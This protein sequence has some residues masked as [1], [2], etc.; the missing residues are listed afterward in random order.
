MLL[1]AIA[2]KRAGNQANSIAEIA[3]SGLCI[4]C[5][6][7]QSIAS[8]DTIDIVMTAD[9][10]ERPIAIADIHDDVFEKITKVCPALEIHGLPEHELSSEANMDDVWGQS[11]QIASGY[12]SDSE[13]RFKGATGGVLTGLAVYLLESKQV[14]FIAHIAS[15]SERPLRNKA[16]LS[17]TRADVLKGAGSRYAPTASLTDFITLLDKEQ[18]FAFIGKPCDIGAVRNLAKIDD[19]VDTYCKYL[20]T[21]V[22]G[23]ASKLTK[24]WGVLDDFGISEKDVSYLRYRGHGNP[25]ATRIETKDGQSF[26]LSY[27]DM[28]KDEGKWEIQSRCKVCADAIGESADIAALDIWEGG[29]P[30]G[31][32]DGFNGIIARTKRG[33]A[34]LDAAVKANAITLEKQLS[35]RDLDNFQPHQ[36]HK[37]KAVWARLEGLK[38]AGSLVPIVTGLRI[39][40]LSLKNDSDYNT[41]EKE[42]MQKRL[43]NGRNFFLIR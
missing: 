34:L 23:G 18:P 22:C 42:G 17:Y 36:V 5:G 25:G 16:H 33:K 21:L 27:L 32:D 37:K 14:D 7:C 38:E 20:L 31:E 29:A 15:D 30:V 26:E 19:R 8:K 35:N 43:K 1:Q 9:G 11:F 24:T 41:S 2:N 40:E 12:A 3:E 10:V 13:L 39:E 6:L 4:G 28:W